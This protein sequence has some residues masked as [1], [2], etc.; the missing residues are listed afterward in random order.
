MK[1]YYDKGYARGIRAI[2]CPD[3]KHNTF[4]GPTQNEEK[5][6]KGFF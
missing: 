3:D 6:F 2:Q 4:H 1:V 5:R